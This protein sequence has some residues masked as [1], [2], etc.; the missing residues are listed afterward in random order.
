MLSRS[1]CRCGLLIAMYADWKSQ[2]SFGRG[3]LAL[4][5]RTISGDS[6]GNP[7]AERE[8]ARSRV[9]VIDG[10]LRKIQLSVSRSFRAFSRRTRL[11]VVRQCLD[12]AGGQFQAFGIAP[13]LPLAVNDL[14]EC[15]RVKVAMQLCLILSKDRQLQVCVR[16][17]HPPKE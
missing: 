2:S 8:I 1:H 9:S 15:P 13:R 16:S 4:K 12:L 3:N 6:T 17:R 7:V 5:S 14:L 11:P 10:L